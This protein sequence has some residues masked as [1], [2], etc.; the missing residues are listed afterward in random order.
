L[1]LNPSELRA[2]L[3]HKFFLSQ[4][5][6]REASIDEASADFLERYMDAFR[7]EQLRLHNLIQI[8]EIKK[9]Q[10]VESEKAGRDIGLEKAAQDWRI[11]YAEIYRAESEALEKQGFLTLEVTVVNRNGIHVRPAGTLS[12][13]AAKFDADVYVSKE[14]M[15][16]FNFMLQ[17][18]PYLNFKSVMLNLLTI[19]A[20]QGTVL[21]FIAYGRQAK[22]VLEAIRELIESGFGEKTKTA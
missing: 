16:H 13:L 8:D 6:G 1:D 14:G 15:D 21:N 2:I 5:L 3:D 18:K 12:T 20:C 7:T 10:W 4:N 19:N 11:K 9:H 17:G 22:E